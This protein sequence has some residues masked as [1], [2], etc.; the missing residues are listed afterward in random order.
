MFGKY[1]IGGFRAQRSNE[2]DEEYAALSEKAKY[3]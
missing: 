2:S 3:S 1:Y